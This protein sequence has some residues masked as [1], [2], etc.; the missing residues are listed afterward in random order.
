MRT[1]ALQ[2]PEIPILKVWY[3]MEKYNLPE[4]EAVKYINQDIAEIEME[5]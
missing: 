1:D 2:F 5:D 3:M 4:E